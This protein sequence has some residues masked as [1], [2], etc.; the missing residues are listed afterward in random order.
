MLPIAQLKV[1]CIPLEIPAPS[2]SQK[3]LY[4]NAHSM[5]N[6]QEELEIYVQSQAQLL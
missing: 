5:G 3:C 6:N 2:A 1:S 4:S